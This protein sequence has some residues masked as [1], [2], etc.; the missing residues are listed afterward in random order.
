MGVMGGIV[1]ILG[2]ALSYL[3]ARSFVYRAVATKQGALNLRVRRSAADTPFGPAVALR[4]LCPRFHTLELP[5]SS[6]LVF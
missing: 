5:F 4:F 1:T 2:R 6:L 3:H